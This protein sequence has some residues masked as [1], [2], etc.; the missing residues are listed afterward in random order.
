MVI[1]RLAEVNGIAAGVGDIVPVDLVALEDRRNR[2]L[3]QVERRRGRALAGLLSR[4]E[5]SAVG[6]HEHAEYLIE[7]RRLRKAR[8]L[9]R[10]CLAI[11]RGLVEPDGV[12]VAGECDGLDVRDAHLH[13]G[14]EHSPVNESSIPLVALAPPTATV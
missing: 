4:A 5:S 14:L 3:R 9:C 12:V 1:G 7:D 13:G 2:L 11:H 6:V 10:R 8:E